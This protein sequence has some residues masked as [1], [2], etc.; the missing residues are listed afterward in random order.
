MKE[1]KNFIHARLKSI[2]EEIVFQRAL[3]TGLPVKKSKH[4]YIVF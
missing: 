1:V 3:K 4:S 2:T